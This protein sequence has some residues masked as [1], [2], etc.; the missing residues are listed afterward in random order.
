LIR[1]A[2][3]S[4][5]SDGNSLEA[6]GRQ[7]N[8]DANSRLFAVERRWHTPELTNLRLC[9]AQNPVQTVQLIEVRCR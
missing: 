6:L 2:L 1:S 4:H 9:F 7:V 3:E 5:S 8:L